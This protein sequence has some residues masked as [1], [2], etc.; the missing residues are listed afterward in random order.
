LL[1]YAEPPEAQPIKL[2]KFILDEMDRILACWDEY[3]R[4]M[5]PAADQM[6]LRALRDHS[7]EM[8]RAVAADIDSP[9]TDDEQVEKSQGESLVDVSSSAASEHGHFR[10]FANFTLIQLSSEFR[11]LRASVLRLWLQQVETVSPDVLDDVVRFN[12]AIDQALAESIVTYS[13]RA[14]HSRDLFDAL[15]GHDLR[16]PLSAMSMAGELLTLENVPALKAAELGG[17][18]MSSARYMSSMVDDMLEFARTRLGNTP[19]PIQPEMANIKAICSRAIN[20]AAAM[21]RDCVFELVVEGKEEAFLDP[22]RTQQL[23]MNLLGNAGQHGARGRPVQLFARM[24]EA[25]TIFQV[26]N[27]GPEIPADLLDTIFE[28]LVRLSAELESATHRTTS[29]GLGLHIAR[30]IATSHGGSITVE[31]RDQRTTFTVV[32]P[33]TVNRS[34]AKA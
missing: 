28:P 23:L 19:I 29:L 21:H 1:L 18:I 33:A 3:A 13:D 27:E 10:H 11:A 14:A 26:V 6:S 25:K 17:R 2:S 9:Q 4:T 24:E 31:S 20:D 12:E 34:S 8:L 15:L 5:T 30:E 7:E 22:D 32:F 16:G